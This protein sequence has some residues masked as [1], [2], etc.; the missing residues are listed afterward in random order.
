MTGLVH[1]GSGVTVARTKK[2]ERDRKLVSIPMAA[3]LMELRNAVS[4]Q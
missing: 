4:Q 1:V 3:A 2:Q